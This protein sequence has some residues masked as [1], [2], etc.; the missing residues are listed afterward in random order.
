M[1][2]VFCNFK[3]PVVTR[4]NGFMVIKDIHPKAKYHFLIIPEKH[5][6]SYEKQSLSEAFEVA[7]QVVSSFNL[8]SYTMTINFNKPRQ[9]VPHAH[10]HLLSD[11]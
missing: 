11:A 9:Q 8:N 4:F 6:G 2:C 5:M 10:L 3:G 7:N 1:N